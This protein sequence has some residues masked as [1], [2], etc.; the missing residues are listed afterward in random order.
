MSSEAKEAARRL[1]ARAGN[2]QFHEDDEDLALVL[3]AVD[4][5]PD[6]PESCTVCGG[7]VTL[8]CYGSTDF[9]SQ[10]CERGV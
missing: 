5:L 2:M 6:P 1:Q 8:I 7:E 10:N 4:A 3:D 9:C